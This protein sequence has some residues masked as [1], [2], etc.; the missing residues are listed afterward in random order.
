MPETKQSLVKF[1]VVRGNIFM[2]SI[3]EQR[4]ARKSA[5]SYEDT[6]HEKIEFS[7]VVWERSGAVHKLPLGGVT[8]LVNTPVRGEYYRQPQT[9]LREPTILINDKLVLPD[10]L[11]TLAP[12]IQREILKRLDSR[13][14]KHSRKFVGKPEAIPIEFQP[15]GRFHLNAAHYGRFSPDEMDFLRPRLQRLKTAQARSKT[16]RRQSTSRT[17]RKS[18]QHRTK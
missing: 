9:D 16:A 15:V 6:N 14:P 4:Y 5:R 3:T 13:Y 7:Q 8:Y 18:T 11:Q 2:L 12:Q 17:R 10:S 1:L